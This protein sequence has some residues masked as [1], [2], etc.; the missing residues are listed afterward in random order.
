MEFDRI[1]R[2]G[3]GERRTDGRVQFDHRERNATKMS[4]SRQRYGAEAYGE[5]KRGRRGADG[6]SHGRR[7]GRAKANRSGKGKSKTFNAFT[8]QKGKTMKQ[9]GKDGGKKGKSGY[10]WKGLNARVGTPKL[11]YDKG[12]S[13]E[14]ARA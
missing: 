10:S 14:K 5:E 1:F 6:S 8:E 11:S 4:Q 9:G 12:R 2:R 13:K 3:Y 7:C